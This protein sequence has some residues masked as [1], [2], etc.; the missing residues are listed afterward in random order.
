MKVS[1]C[2]YTKDRA[3]WL[4][5]SI[6]TIL[7]QK[8]VDLEILI[9]NDGSTD[10]TQQVL[11]QYHDDPRFRLFQR[12]DPHLFSLATG[13]YVCSLPDDDW[14]SGDDS[15]VRRARVLEQ[16]PSLA[17]VFS[18]IMGHSSDGTSR[19]LLGMGLVSKEDKLS[20]AAPFNSL[21]LDCFVPWPS[22]MF[23]R[24]IAPDFDE[25]YPSEGI[26][27]RD[28][29]WWQ[30]LSRLGDAAFL[31]QPTASLRCHDGQM[32]NTIGFKQGGFLRAHLDIWRYWIEKQ[33]HRPTANDWHYMRSTAANL[34]TQQHKQSP[35]EIRAQALGEAFEEMDTFKPK[36][37]NAL[38]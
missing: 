7:N 21:F 1:V 12:G 3:H 25:G 30:K 29:F 19:G 5:E 32:S 33:G 4:P 8:G 10:A 13:D 37:I 6:G 38:A 11:D 2:M 20:G 35:A 9:L 34:V 36:E 17:F 24:S 27:C 28:W 26:L 23:R 15:L 18:P 14:L 31:V 16:D 22:G